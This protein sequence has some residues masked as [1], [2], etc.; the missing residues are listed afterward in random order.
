MIASR[1]CRRI[2]IIFAILFSLSAPS[3]HAQCDSADLNLD[4]RIVAQL[5][6]IEATKPTSRFV[7]SAMLPLALGLPA[8]L[9]GIGSS[10]KDRYLAETGVVMFCADVA[11]L[12]V[13]FA[14]KNIVQRER[15]FRAYP[16]CITPGA[17]DDYYSFPSGH[18]TGSTVMATYLSLRYPKWYVI[19]PSV[20]YAAYTWYARMNLGVH[21]P[22]DI[23]VGILVGAATGV[24][25]YELSD[26]LAQRV[27]E[28]LPTAGIVAPTGGT[29]FSFSIPF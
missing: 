12:A 24:L 16:N 20:S 5:N 4:A 15:P 9:Y 29:R 23:L 14:T 22:S 11:S 19:A 18:A 1:L 28:L 25:A 27:P 17:D 6:S 26:E 2:S 13:V 7:S 3:A 10:S 21:Y 8:V